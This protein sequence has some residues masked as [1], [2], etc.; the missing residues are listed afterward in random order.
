MVIQKKFV[1]YMKKNHARRENMQIK[2]LMQ[3]SVDTLRT[4][5]IKVFL[6]KTINYIYKV[7][8]MENHPESP[9][10]MFMDVLF[11]NGC[12]LP[13]PSRYRVSHQREQLFA[14][15]MSSNEV[16][17]E[18]V[19]LDLVKRY[20]V[21]I[22]FRC[23][24]TEIIEEFIKLAK[25]H[26]KVV[27]FDIDDLV[28][29]C[30]YT[31]QIKYIQNMSLEEKCHY[32]D[33]VNR[34]QKT[35][36]LCDGAITTT[37]RLAVELR[38]YVPEVFIN[39]NVA[40]DRMLELS[41]Q[42]IFDRDKLPYLPLEQVNTRQEK[43]KKASA[44]LEQKKMSGRIAIG[45]FSGSI[46]HNDDIDLILPILVRVMNDFENVELH[47]VGELSLPKELLPF[48]ERVVAR[49]F[50][51]WEEL[52]RLI[53]SVDI[54]IAPLEDTVFNEAKS[55]NKWVEAALVKVPTVASGIGAFADMI[56][57]GKTGFLCRSLDEWY[58]KIALL[59]ENADLRKTIAVQAYQKVHAIACTLHT[60]Y[61]L[62]EYL[63]TKMTTNLIMI[64]PSLQ[65]SGG[66]LV[67]LKHCLMLQ[68]AGIDVTV[69]NDGFGEKNIIYEGQE[70][71][72]ISTKDTQIHAK[73]DKAVATLWT[74]V[75]FIELYPN[76]KERYYL[77]QGFEPNFYQAG[78][79][80]RFVANQTY[81]APVQINYI[82]VSRWCEQWL[83][84]K[85][86]QKVS[87]APN[88]IE[89]SRF[90]QKQRNLNKDKIR[91]LVEGN[92]DDYYKNVDES[93]R[94]VEK[95]DKE[96]F[97]IWFMSYQGKPK[98]WYHVDKFL[99]KVPNEQ[100]GK[101]YMDCDILIK[102]SILESFSYPP[103]EMMATGGFVVVA[104][105]AG[106]VEYL[107]DRENCLF[108]DHTDLQTAVEA[109]EEITS[110]ETLRERLYLNGI[111]TAKKRD[112]KSIKR[113]IVDLYNI[114]DK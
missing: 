52:P 43:K 19:T 17:F 70:I 13:H 35:L 23:P 114:K 67:A 78:S 46:T 109:I 42:A 12:Y 83:L 63:R 3:K 24:H 101:V 4:E 57:D 6:K 110:N 90:Q 22:F 82:T 7:R 85:Y 31:D 69:I 27:L 97:E 91:I 15:G 48:K 11:I 55:E 2:M 89:L 38:K 87:Y 33:G 39:R 105:N 1:I 74:T 104:P 96:K 37:E 36:L 99:H 18:D 94:I 93:F 54:N 100:V 53:A 49:P 86:K 95:L 81:S 20:R 21:F 14:N 25:N 64:L 5:G 40:S 76:I 60:G 112:W 9:D 73:I 65:I 59:I 71:F 62:V 47:F 107:V 66:V 56:E 32:D 98:N 41:E 16:F 51:S 34:M 26:H 44:L 106:N 58:E 80:N 84:E 68:D 72:T 8:N 28:F 61:P 45:Y 111:E 102:S 10:K 50:V 108:Y 29:D 79:Y 77:V 113:Q 30:A 75:A 103:L 88:G 92:S